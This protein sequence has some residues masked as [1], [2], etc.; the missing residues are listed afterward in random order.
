MEQREVEKAL[1]ETFPFCHQLC[2]ARLHQYKNIMQGYNG[3][4]GAEVA[5]Q[6]QET[7]VCVNN[8]LPSN[9]HDILSWLPEGLRYYAQNRFR[10]YTDYTIM[11]NPD[12]TKDVLHRKHLSAYWEHYACDLLG[13][14][15]WINAKI[16][17]ALETTKEV[18][19][20]V[21]CHSDTVG[22]LATELNDA[23]FHA[24]SDAVDYVKIELLTQGWLP[25]SETTMSTG[26]KQMVKQS[27]LLKCSFTDSSVLK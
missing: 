10:L 18:E 16:V 7:D 20:D 19:I 14:V 11:R 15:Q 6:L 22:I 17:R 9:Y 25:F 23:H 5:R 8:N 12:I 2:P 26:Y 24:A 3:N 4:N 1:E 13:K 21:T 27:I